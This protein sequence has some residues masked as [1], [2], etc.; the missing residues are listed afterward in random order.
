M[1]SKIYLVPAFHTQ[2]IT[3]WPVPVHVAGGLEPVGFLVQLFYPFPFF[4]I[5]TFVSWELTYS[6]TALSSQ[7]PI[8]QVS[9]ISI[10]DN[11]NCM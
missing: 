1:R 2:T 7:L 8:I 9:I 11:L 4:Q 6:Q 5:D 10:L 3:K